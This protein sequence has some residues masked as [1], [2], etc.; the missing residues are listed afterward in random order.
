MGNFTGKPTEPVPAPITADENNAP[1]NDP[2]QQQPPPPASESVL[3]DPLG[4]VMQLFGGGTTRGSRAVKKPAAMTQDERNAY[5]TSLGVQVNKLHAERL[6]LIT[7][8]RKYMIIGREAVADRN[9]K[10]AQHAQLIASRQEALET[11][12]MKTIGQFESFQ[13]AIIQG[14]LNAIS[15]DAM[16]EVVRVQRD[17]MQSMGDMAGLERLAAEFGDLMEQLDEQQEMLT[18][19]MDSSSSG[20][21]A[22]RPMTNRQLQAYFAEFDPAPPPQPLQPST[23]AEGFTDVPLSTRQ[24]KNPKPTSRSQP[25]P[26]PPPH[27]PSSPPQSS[28]LSLPSTTTM[29][30]SNTNARKS[31]VTTAATNETRKKPVAALLL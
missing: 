23:D 28:S 27:A 11:Q 8:K 29:L 18:E 14:N 15:V 17:Q 31:R 3:K 9:L 12:V 10:S 22:A 2:S 24:S 7:K 25:R 1:V 26:S 19:A 30:S 4:G 21:T 16:R 6:R 13:D 5:A 20:T